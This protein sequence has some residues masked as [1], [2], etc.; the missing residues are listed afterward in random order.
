MEEKSYTQHTESFEDVP[1][2][3]LPQP[4]MDLAIK[5]YAFAALFFI[6]GIT[7]S[8]CVKSIYGLIVTFP[9]LYLVYLASSIRRDYKKGKIT[10]CDALC[11]SVRDK[12]IMNFAQ[13]SYTVVFEAVNGAVAEFEM[14]VR[15]NKRFEAGVA[16]RIYFHSTYDS[17]ILATAGPIGSEAEFRA[18]QS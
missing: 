13:N 14:P 1:A 4:L 12:G 7:V 6:I 2:V 3:D 16:Y 18:Q 10:E 17:T 11:L 15:K 5:R 8:I 9:A